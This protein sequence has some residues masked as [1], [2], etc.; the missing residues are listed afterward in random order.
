MIVSKAAMVQTFLPHHSLS[1]FITKLAHDMECMHRLMEHFQNRNSRIDYVILEL[2]LHLLPDEIPRKIFLTL[3]DNQKL[4][5]SHVNDVNDYSFGRE[6]SIREENGIFILTFW[7]PIENE[8]WE[9]TVDS[10]RA[11]FMSV[12]SNSWKL[13]FVELLECPG[14]HQ[15]VHHLNYCHQCGEKLYVFESAF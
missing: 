9:V 13:R 4:M 8:L 15:D 12:K 10:R 1:R 14:C 2:S 11:K 6:E 3:C 5:L 7:L